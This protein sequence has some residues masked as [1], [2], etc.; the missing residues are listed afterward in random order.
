MN[1]SGTHLYVSGL[2][3]NNE[4]IIAKNLHNVK[5]LSSGSEITALTWGDTTETDI[6]IGTKEQTV[7]VYDSEFKAFSSCM[8]TKFGQGPIVGLTRYNK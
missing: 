3:I 6:L 4:K 2:Q 7:K 1:T 8:K 5:N